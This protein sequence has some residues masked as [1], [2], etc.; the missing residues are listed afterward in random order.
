VTDYQT[1]H[2]TGGVSSGGNATREP[3][4]TPKNPKNRI[5]AFVF[6][7][8]CI[9]VIFYPRTISDDITKVDRMYLQQND[10]GEYDYIDLSS[11][12]KVVLK[13]DVI[14]G[15]V[16]NEYQYVLFGSYIQKD[17]YYEPILWRVLYAHQCKVLLLSEYIIDTRKFDIV[18]N[19]WADSEIKAFQNLKKKQ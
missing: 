11:T 7:L 6:S 12:A 3:Q 16:A 13:L 18:D 8:L 9:F 5:L 1:H 15:W 10:K 14:H 2:D 4:T 19:T 17:G